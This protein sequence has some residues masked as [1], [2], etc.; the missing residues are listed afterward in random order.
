MRKLNREAMTPR[1]VPD[2]IA[3][4]LLDVDFAALK[5]MGVQYIAF[6]ADS[7]LVS[8]RGKALSPEVKKFLRQNRKLFKKWCIASNRITNDLLP[9]AE[10]MDAQVI[11]A[12]LFTR[13][14]S[15]RFFDRVIRHFGGKP[16][17]IA[18][19]GDKLIADMYGGKR[20][21][22]MTVWVER[23]GKDSRHDQLLGVRKFEKR[24]MRRY[25]DG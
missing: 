16:Q 9:L 11:Q 25:L 13:K 4:S 12:T 15:R 8:Y 23:I 3:T 10:N 5:K 24:L 19:V 1:F 18:M 14:P 2:F 7:T 22:L 17:K 20:A 6:D 21:G